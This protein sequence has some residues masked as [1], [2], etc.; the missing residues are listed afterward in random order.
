MNTK[1]VLNITD[2]GH[3]AILYML[4]VLEH[5][6]DVLRL[7]KRHQCLLNVLLEGRN[8]VMRPRTKLGIVLRPNIVKW[9][10]VSRV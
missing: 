5:S 1:Y 4:A 9:V 2:S 8:T 3:Y 10:E 7:F 6:A